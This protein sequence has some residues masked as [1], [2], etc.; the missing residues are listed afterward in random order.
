M[1]GL[2]SKKTFAYFA[3]GC[4]WCIAP[5]FRDQPG[6]LSVTAG[7]SGGDE[8]D[9]SYEDVKAGKTHHRETIRVL[10]D[11]SAISYESLLDLFLWNT[12]PFDAGG[13]FI[14]RGPSY[15]LAIYYN[16]ESEHELIIKKLTG[17]A[18]EAG[19]DPSIT[20]APFLSF[21]PAPEEHQDF[22]RKNPGRFLQELE[23]SG[24]S[25]FFAKKEASFR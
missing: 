2:K 1:S 15:T 13:Q 20:V 8:P 17:L 23:E 10:Y 19:I 24:R 3:G 21:Y 16:C 6:V 9:P 4:F 18:A 7:F 14:D 12:D 25:S 22:D 5:V 11:P